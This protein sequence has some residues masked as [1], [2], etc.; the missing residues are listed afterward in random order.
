[1]AKPMRR[2]KLLEVLRQLG[3]TTRQAHGSHLAIMHGGRHI[4]TVNN[5]NAEVGP[6]TVQSLKMHMGVNLDDSPCG[7]R[8]KPLSVALA[9]RRPKLA[10]VTPAAKPPAESPVTPAAKPPAEPPSKL[11]AWLSRMMANGSVI[12]HQDGEGVVISY[13]DCDLRLAKTGRSLAEI[14]AAL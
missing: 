10:P 2:T 12:I 3:A 13:T 5:A 14:E 7:K 9:E 1:M 4:G 6:G 11:A 8:L